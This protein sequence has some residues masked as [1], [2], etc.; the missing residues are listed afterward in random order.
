[1]KPI[2]GRNVAIN[3]N[4]KELTDRGLV[5]GKL[6]QAIDWLAIRE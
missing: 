2:V 1:L 6:M 5:D 4:W 3:A